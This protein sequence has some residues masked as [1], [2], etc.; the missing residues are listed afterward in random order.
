M[1]PGMLGLVAHPPPP[2]SCGDFAPAA[3]PNL[4]LFR[5]C[6]SF[7]LSPAHPDAKRVAEGEQVNG[8]VS[9]AQ[10][11][12]LRLR[13]EELQGVYHGKTRPVLPIRTSIVSPPWYIAH[14][15]CRA[16]RGVCVD[17]DAA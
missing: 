6:P 9:K 4:A 12:V 8:R 11:D 17:V 14:D 5:L 16:E 10:E 7:F 3:S 15:W 13:C 2:R 1:T